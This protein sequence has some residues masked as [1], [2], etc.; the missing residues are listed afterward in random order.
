MAKKELNRAIKKSKGKLWTEICN[1]LNNDIWGKAYQ[2]VAKK[3]GRTLPEPP[4]SP[5][6]MNQI[7]AELFLKHSAR[8]KG[9]HRNNAEVLQFTISELQIAVKTLKLGKAP[10]PDS[11]STQVIK[12]TAQKSPYILLNKYN[13]C[14]V[15][16]TFPPVWKRQRLV[17][18][19]KGKG[20]SI[21]AS[22]YRP[23]CMLDI[24]GKLLKKLIQARLQKDVESTGDFFTNQHGFRKGRST[25]G[26][27]NEVVEI[28]TRSWVGSLKSRKVCILLALDVK[29]AFNSASWED[30]LK[31]LGKRFQVKSDILTMVD[32]YLD[33]RTLIV[34]TTEGTESHKITA[35]VPQGS[36]MGPDLWNTDYDELLG[37][38]LPRQAHSV[39]G[40]YRSYY[41]R[42][43]R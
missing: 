27:I 38:P 9:H 42:R 10:G 12:L 19:D 17:L 26:A 35:G 36:V 32:S 39:C 34:E 31:A 3:L 1:D 11:I 2:I 43:Q 30:I 18:L 21:I 22:S 23:L 25:I 7:V 14:L 37:I 29:N 5:A 8:E 33:H 24:T 16:G 13:A 15:T 40:S 41:C 6:M 28:A 20:P 4:K